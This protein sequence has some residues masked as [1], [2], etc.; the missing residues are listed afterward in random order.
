MKSL[1]A[2]FVLSLLSVSCNYYL[3]DEAENL[4]KHSAFAKVLYENDILK[5]KDINNTAEYVESLTTDPL[6]LS[7][8][9]VTYF[10][11]YTNK[12]IWNVICRRKTLYSYQLEE[13]EEKA[14]KGGTLFILGIDPI[15]LEMLILEKLFENG[16]LPVDVL[17]QTVDS[18]SRNFYENGIQSK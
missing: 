12:G 11:Y 18:D 3:S 6:S 5:T 2:L 1:I 16:L 13:V 17:Q 7:K 8:A 4:L 14:P 10:Y 15:Y 9:P